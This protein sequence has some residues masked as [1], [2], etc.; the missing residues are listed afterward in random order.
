MR[1]LAKKNRIR[2]GAIVF[3]AAAIFLAGC[4]PPGPRAL[5][6]GKKLLERGDYAG[7]VAEL[8]TAASLLPA[9]AQAW[10][11][12][13]VALQRDGQPDDAAKAYGRALSLDRDLTEAHYNLGCLWLEQNKPDA[14]KNEFTAYALR[15]GNDPAGWLK[16]GSAQLRL[17]DLASAEK[18]FSTALN[19]NPNNAEAL[20]GLGLARVQRDRPREAA[21]FFA[22]AIRYHPD[23]APAILNLATV[24]HE[25]LRDDKLALEN[26]RAYLALTPR[27]ANWD[28]VNAIVSDL[29]RPVTVAANQPPPNQNQTAPPTIPAA[30]ETRTQTTVVVRA[31][32]PPKTTPVVRNNYTPPPRTSPPAPVQV[33]KVQPEPV[34]VTTPRPAAPTVKPPVYAEP[35]A[36]QTPP[37]PEPSRFNPLNWF[38]SSAPEKK[39]DVNEVTPLPPP[40]S[41]NDRVSS[42]PLPSSKTNAAAVS[43]SFA[44][45]PVVQQSVAPQPPIHIVPSAPPSFPRYLY[46]SPRQPRAGDRK[47]A[48]RAFAEAQQFE[49]KQQLAQAMKSY[50]QAAKLD[51]GWFEAQYNYGVLAYRLRDFPRSL[52]AYEMALAIRPDSADARYNFALALKA[53]GYAPD[54]VNELEKI[55]ASNPDETRAHLALG[56]LYAQQ[57]NDPARAR[58]HYLKV[59]QLDPRNPQATDIRFWLS[60]NPQ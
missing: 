24:A 53:A 4:A 36:D 21:Q 56:N 29:E 58:A 14:A 17:Q 43:N 37:Q 31:T 18:S 7:A 1:M 46:L 23:Y 30:V 3:I 9:N 55:L 26:Y 5:L 19:L 28:E 25:H 33:V 32:L 8:K 16:L 39:F 51:P 60:A 40:D 10:N 15:R 2:G 6:N 34:I 57:L 47:S 48:A 59:L 54:A 45:S 42:T 12:Y 22:A 52:A 49:Q 35:P 44:P 20:N 11:Y 50:Q 38:H 13:G 27:P 41:A